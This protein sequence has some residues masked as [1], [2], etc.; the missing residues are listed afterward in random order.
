[1]TVDNCKICR[2]PGRRR[3]IEADWADGMSAVGIAKAMTDNGWP[4]TSTTVLKHLKEHAGPEAAIRVPPALSKRD[5]AVWVRDRIMDKVE[6]IEQ[7]TR[8]VITKDGEMVE[9]PFDILDKE[10]QP[11]L[12]S[13]L[14]AQAILD[15]REANQTSAKISLFGLMLGITDGGGD[16]RFAPLELSSGE[17]DENE[18]E[19][20]ARAVD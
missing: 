16:G 15:K 6:E 12:G 7:G 19:G 18:I 1:V 4:I 5:A 9:V 11:A 8:T 3:L 20:T 10:L 2:A 17:E 13:M 14:K